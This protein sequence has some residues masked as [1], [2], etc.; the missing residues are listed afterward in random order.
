[1]SNLSDIKKHNK[2]TAIH[3]GHPDSW[4]NYTV[5]LPIAGKIPGKLW[6]KEHLG[7]TGMEISFNLL[8]P[9]ASIPFMHAHKQN[10]E[11]YIFISG[12]GQMLVDN[13]IIDVSAGSAVRISPSAMRCW[14][15]TGK[16]NLVHLV[17]QCKEG[18]LEQ[19]TIED[20]LPS[21]EPPEWPE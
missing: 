5:E 7:L 6:L 1:M 19:W 8:P 18:S 2:A 10:E 17:I 20:G 4:I 15:N 13:E 3:A 16:D 14:R 12:E 21:T 9:G 11:L